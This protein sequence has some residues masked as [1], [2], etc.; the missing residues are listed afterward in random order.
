[1]SEITITINDSNA[2]ENGEKYR[3]WQVQQILNNLMIK[4][5][6]GTCIPVYIDNGD[7]TFSR[8]KL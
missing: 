7:G 8:N 3:L 4:K 5:D 2:K 6:D 1:M